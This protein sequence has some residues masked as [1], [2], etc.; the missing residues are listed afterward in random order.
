MKSSVQLASIALSA[1][2]GLYAAFIIVCLMPQK[3]EIPV[4]GDIGY[5]SHATLASAEPTPEPSVIAAD[6]TTEVPAVP[7]ITETPAS[8]SVPELPSVPADLIP[9]E[10]PAVEPISDVPDVPSVPEL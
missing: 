4:P 7:A 9:Q 3:S 6:K 1:A 8:D 5:E 2:V 10:T